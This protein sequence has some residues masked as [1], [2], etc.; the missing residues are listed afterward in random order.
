MECYLTLSAGSLGGNF[1]GFQTVNPLERVTLITF[2][3]SLNQRKINFRVIACI[4]IR[5]INSR[6]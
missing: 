2:L 3:R 1:I 6:K 5:L 4:M